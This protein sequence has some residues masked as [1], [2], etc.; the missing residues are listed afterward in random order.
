[1]IPN[2]TIWFKKVLG[3]QR[4]YNRYILKNLFTSDFTLAD[5]SKYVSQCRCRSASVP[6]ST[7]E[8]VPSVAVKVASVLAHPLVEVL[9]KRDPVWVHENEK[10]TKSGVSHVT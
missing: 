5:A 7:S 10:W 9:V 6:V 1:V 2:Q 8:I 4:R 3:R